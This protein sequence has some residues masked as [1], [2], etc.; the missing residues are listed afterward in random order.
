VIE[1][2]VESIDVGRNN[3]MTQ[4]IFRLA[5]VCL[6]ATACNADVDVGGPQT[7]GADNMGSAGS[8]NPSS[9]GSAN[10]S[11]AGSASAGSPSNAGTGGGTNP[12]PE[13][14]ADFADGNVAC[15]T[16][17]DCC[18]VVNDCANQAYVVGI[19][20]KDKVAALVAIA[21][22]DRSRCTG[23]IAPAVEVTCENAKC[24]GSLVEFTASS[25]PDERLF[26][27]HCGTIST[28]DTTAQTG[29]MFGCGGG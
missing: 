20:D 8:A 1:R 13:D 29:S 19:D 5:W 15:D 22:Q 4:K 21:E 23:C 25:Q 17:A 16:D 27:D 14:P 26:Q 2:R 18:V 7:G 11:S 10:P 9:A 3:E 6:L 28:P 12:E 24:V